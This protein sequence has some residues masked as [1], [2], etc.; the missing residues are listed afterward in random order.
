[1]TRE[2]EDRRKISHGN[3]REKCWRIL[4]QEAR[5]RVVD[6]DKKEE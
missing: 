2:R 3:E 6:C 4:Q 1:M 5:S